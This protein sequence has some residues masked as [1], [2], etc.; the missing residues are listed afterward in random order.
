MNEQRSFSNDE[1]IEKL[2]TE[3]KLRLAPS[4][5]HGI[6]VFAIR[7][8]PRGQR[9]YSDNMPVLYRLPYANFGKLFPEV[10]E[11]LL[12][13]NPTIP[14]GSLFVYPDAR[15]QAYMNHSDTPNYNAQLDLVMVDIPKGTEVF[16]DYRRIEGWEE[17][18]PWLKK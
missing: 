11:I 15:M 7:D 18:F 3:C 16:E 14:L 10:S 1:A 5:V 17:I 2:N 9:I 8:I 12:E 4:S 6:G 13:R